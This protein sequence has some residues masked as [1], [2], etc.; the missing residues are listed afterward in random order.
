MA[1]LLSSLVTMYLP[2]IKRWFNKKIKVVIVWKNETLEEKITQIIEKKKIIED[3]VR[4]EVKNQ[5]LE[6]LNEDKKGNNK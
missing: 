5:L 2:K 1:S 6:I 3:I 4:E